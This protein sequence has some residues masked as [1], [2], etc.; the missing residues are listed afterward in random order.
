M[1]HT[2]NPI[3]IATRVNLIAEAAVKPVRRYYQLD[4]LLNVCEGDE[5]VCPDEDRHAL[6]GGHL[7]EELRRF[8]SIRVYIP[9]GTSPTNAIAALGKFASWIEN[10]PELFQT[11]PVEDPTQQPLRESTNEEMAQCRT[12]AGEVLKRA[13]AQLFQDRILELL[14]GFHPHCLDW[15]M[16]D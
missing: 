16:F 14:R 5:T 12:S 2:N 11:S 3:D 7:C 4:C 8:D 13:Y 1:K 6:L 15:E 10:K 9:F